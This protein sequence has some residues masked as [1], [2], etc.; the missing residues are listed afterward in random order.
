[1][2]TGLP[3]E[4]TLIRRVPVTGAGQDRIGTTT[5]LECFQG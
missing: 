3:F 1:M 4:T 5:R 2:T